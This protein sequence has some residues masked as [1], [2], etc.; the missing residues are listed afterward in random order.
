MFIADEFKNWDTQT[1]IDGQ[2][3]LARPMKFSGLYGLRLRVKEAWQVLIGK[4]DA[5]RF[6]KQ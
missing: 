1:E 4:A 6:I 3:V 5:V 2:W